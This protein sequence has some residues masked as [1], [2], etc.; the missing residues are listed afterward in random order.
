V[1]KVCTL[2]FA[3][4]ALVLAC[5]Q[6]ADAGPGKA[7]RKAKKAQRRARAKAEFDRRKKLEEIGRWIAVLQRPDPLDRLYASWNLQTLEP[8]TTGAVL[9]ALKTP[10]KREVQIAFCEI[11]SESPDR[12]RV[13]PALETLVRESK[14]ERVKVAALIGAARLLT[15]KSRELLE[16]VAESGT[17]AVRRAAVVALGMCEYPTAGEA[18]RSALAVEDGQLRVA[19]LRAIGYIKDRRYIPDCTQSLMDPRRLVVGTAANTLGKIGDVAI[20]DK[21]L[22]ALRRVKPGGLRFYLLEGLSRLGRQAAIEELLGYLRDPK[23]KAQADAAVVL[24]EIGEPKAYPVFRR[25]L[26]ESLKGKHLPGADVIIARALGIQGI[27]DGIPEL[28][29]SLVRGRAAVKREAA[30]SLGLLRAKEAIDPLLKTATSGDRRV[31]AAALL[32]LAQIGTEKAAGPL[33]RALKDGDPSVRY[34]ALTALAMSGNRRAIPGMQKLLVDPHPFIVEM[35]K[36]SVAVLEEKPRQAFESRNPVHLSRLWAL[37]RE[38]L[39]RLEM[40]RF[41]GGSAAVP[42]AAITQE[43]VSEEA[44]VSTCGG[45]HPPIEFTVTTKKEVTVGHREGKGAVDYMSQFEKAYRLRE[46][47]S[48]A[49]ALVAGRDDRK[50]E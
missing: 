33:R 22:A 11:L 1:V 8:E 16:T 40:P 14:D 29:A 23:H 26:L 9:E 38:Y 39:L 32:A 21:L 28:I 5:P 7:A 46:L 25:V 42:G 15:P 6:A 19:A 24:Y 44:F 31:R 10:L 37:E 18:A 45:T 13:L 2:G 41:G 50:E 43:V 20:A 12:E 27:K 17:L 4:T 36:E 48:K 3:L 49:A 34:A 47:R 35:A 30:Y